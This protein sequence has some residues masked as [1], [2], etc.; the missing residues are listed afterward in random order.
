MS[1]SKKLLHVVNTPRGGVP[2]DLTTSRH[3]LDRMVGALVL[4]ALAG[5]GSVPQ[6]QMRQAQMQTMQM[7]RQNQDALAQLSQSQQLAGQI[8]G[9]VA[10]LQAANAQL[11]QE[12]TLAQ[13]NAD[14]NGQ[15]LANLNDERGQLHERYRNLLTGMNSSTQNPLG[16]HVNQK[17]EELARRYPEFEFDAQSGVAKFQGDL[18]FSSGS[19]EL[20]PDSHKILEEFAEIM[21]S[22]E[23][24]QFHVVVVGHTDDRPIVRAAT[25]NKHESNWDLSVHRS[26]SVV[27]ALEKRGMAGHRMAASGYSLH[28]PSATNVSDSSRQR[29]RRVEIYV[30]PADAVPGM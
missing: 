13:Q 3:R 17:F 16:A 15:R 8:G 28:R 12:V 19:D 5:C 21:N 6:Y 24:K 23:A 30:T 18:L 9:E 10:Q 1:W 4:A 25:K 26:V 14:V 27:K 20:R 7:Y 22:S 11:R 29:N 2:R